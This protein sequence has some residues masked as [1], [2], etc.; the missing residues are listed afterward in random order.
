[1]LE[2]GLRYGFALLDL[3][4]SSSRKPW[5]SIITSL[6]LSGVNGESAP[7]ISLTVTS[8]GLGR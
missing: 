5:S 4:C 2:I 1:M 3:A 8:D 6:S 7:P